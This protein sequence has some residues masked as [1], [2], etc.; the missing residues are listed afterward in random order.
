MCIRDRSEWGQKHGQPAAA[1]SDIDALFEK[2]GMALGMD[3][4]KMKTAMTQNQY[5]AKILSLIHI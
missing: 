2:Y 4:Q 3:L 5:S 1:P